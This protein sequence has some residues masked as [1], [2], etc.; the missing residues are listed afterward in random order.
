MDE[1][2]RFYRDN[3]INSFDE[4]SDLDK[5]VFQTACEYAVS[6]GSSLMYM[7]DIWKKLQNK[8]LS[9]D[10][11]HKSLESLHNLGF[12]NKTMSYFNDKFYYVFFITSAGFETYVQKTYPDFSAT[13]TKVSEFVKKTY[14]E[15][16]KESLKS[17]LIAHVVKQPKM[18]VNHILE[19]LHN[20]GMIKLIQADRGNWMVHE[21]LTLS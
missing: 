9:E 2:T 10:Q 18:L 19:K 3:S 7:A 17:E 15:G 16:K 5:V 13:F 11:V 12:V 6:V 20:Q 21:V 1:F 4:L 14:L 8:G